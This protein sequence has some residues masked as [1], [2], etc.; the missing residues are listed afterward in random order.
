MTKEELLNL[1]K[2]LNNNGCELVVYEDERKLKYYIINTMK[3]MNYEPLK[4]YEFNPDE[5]IFIY[6]QG[7]GEQCHVFTPVP[8]L[9]GEMFISKDR[10]YDDVVEAVDKLMEE[11]AKVKTFKAMQY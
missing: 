8:V 4:G 9:I 6:S 11:D 1:G 7:G 2:E 5:V 3:Q 10:T